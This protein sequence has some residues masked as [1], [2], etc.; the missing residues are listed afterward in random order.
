MPGVG[1]VRV[2]SYATKDNHSKWRWVFDKLSD[3]G[4]NSIDTILMR[5]TALVVNDMDPMDNLGSQ[6]ALEYYM[7]RLRDNLDSYLAVIEK[8]RVM[9][10][11]RETAGRSVQE[12]RQYLAKAQQLEDRLRADGWFVNKEESK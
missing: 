12:E 5:A 2:G 4:V 8:Y 11:L 3:Q 6:M 7:R 1:R 10:K 9:L